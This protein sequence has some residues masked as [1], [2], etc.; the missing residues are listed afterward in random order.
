MF[1]QVVVVV[2]LLYSSKTWCLPATA[3][4]PLEDF[5]VEDA[6]RLTGMILRKVK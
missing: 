5:H 1:Y 4:R 3:R 6:R 2:V